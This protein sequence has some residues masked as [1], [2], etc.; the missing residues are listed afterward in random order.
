MVTGLCF[1]PPKT[2]N[3]RVWIITKIFQFQPYK[4]QVFKKSRLSQCT[5]PHFVYLHKE[6]LHLFIFLGTTVHLCLFYSCSAIVFLS[7][8][9]APSSG[10]YSNTDRLLIPE[11]FRPTLQASEP[12]SYI[13]TTCRY[14]SF[15]IKNVSFVMPRSIKAARYLDFCFN[16]ATLHG[17]VMVFAFI[18][19]NCVN[20]ILFVLLIYWFL[21]PHRC[22]TFAF[23]KA[24]WIVLYIKWVFQL[25]S[26]PT[27]VDLR[28]CLQ[29]YSQLSSKELLN[30]CHKV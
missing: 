3:S 30:I 23:C 1:Y 12:D 5:D 4:R 19:F 8:A 14:L 17:F 20:M 6:I 15:Q 2:L 29:D 25:N 24:L 18:P 10:S 13:F 22:N 11:Q 7:V 16:G 26:P 28:M 9:L 21:R 27:V